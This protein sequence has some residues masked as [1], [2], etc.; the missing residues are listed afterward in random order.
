MGVFRPTAPFLT[1][2]VDAIKKKTGCDL[3]PVLSRQLDDLGRVIQ[4]EDVARSILEVLK[5]PA[6]RGVPGP[7]LHARMN[8]LEPS[9]VAQLMQKLAVHSSR[10]VQM[11]RWTDKIL[12]RRLE[13]AFNLFLQALS[14]SEVAQSGE[15]PTLLAATK[16]RLKLAN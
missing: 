3:Q 7:K 6:Y 15:Y 13:T 1:G 14:R 10:V 8:D 16:P 11:G 4:S 9:E 2:V 12:I 5:D